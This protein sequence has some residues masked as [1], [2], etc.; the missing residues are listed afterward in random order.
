MGGIK[1]KNLKAALRKMRTVKTWQLLI[2]LILSL[3]IEA[4]LLRFNHIHMTDI[5]AEVAAADESG[6]EE[7]IK[8]ALNKLKDYVNSH[9]VV[10]VVEKNGISSITFGSGPVYLEKQYN[11]KASAALAEAEEHAA[12]DENPNGNVFAKA[13]AVCQ[14]LAQQ[15]GWSWD[16]PE[17]INCYTNEIAKYPTT[18]KIEDTYA[19]TLPSTNLFRYDFASPIWTFSPVG[20]IGIICLILAIIVLIRFII[21]LLLKIALIFIKN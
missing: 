12:T 14:P 1:R 3:F 4:T 8:N 6:D 2:I 9:T 17:Y 5:K 16:T 11:R 13:M 15:N 18:D 10:N 20:I 19:A 21:W 7:A